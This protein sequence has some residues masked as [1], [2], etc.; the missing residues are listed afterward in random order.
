MAIP[1][2]GMQ[3]LRIRRTAALKSEAAFEVLDLPINAVPSARA[4]LEGREDGKHQGELV[5][6]GRTS[7]QPDRSLASLLGPAD[8]IEVRWPRPIP[9]LVMRP[10][11]TAEGLILWDIKP[12]GDRVR[13]RL[14]YPHS[15][16][17]RAIRIPH[18]RGL[19]LLGP[20]PRLARD[21]L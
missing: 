8:R 15:R 2:A 11:G 3:R 14:T 17:L 10:Q 6:R 7:A 20:G 9:E 5:S 4:I 21:V 16:E 12:A 19:I 1:V 13:V 18:P